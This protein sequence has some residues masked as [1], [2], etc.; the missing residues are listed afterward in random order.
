MKYD[1][2][3][4][5]LSEALCDKKYSKEI[6]DL[7]QEVL[8]FI[9]QG[10]SKLSEQGEVGSKKMSIMFMQQDNKREYEAIAKL[11]SSG[12][13]ESIEMDYL[14]SFKLKWYP[15]EPINTYQGLTGY[16][17]YDNSY[18]QLCYKVS[19]RYREY[20]AAFNGTMQKEKAKQLKKDFKAN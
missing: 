19:W 17:P 1:D 16:L 13:I 9:F 7:K 15:H 6:E 4:Y 5:N 10:F 18:C 11:I 2:N 3:F 14:L 12:A 20:F 8:Q